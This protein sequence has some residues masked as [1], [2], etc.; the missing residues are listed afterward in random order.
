MVQRPRLVHNKHSPRFFPCLT[1]TS[2][3]AETVG[4]LRLPTNAASLSLLH[5]IPAFL[6]F[7][8][9]APAAIP[10]VPS[11]KNCGRACSTT[12]M[13]VCAACM[14]QTAS[15]CITTKR[16]KPLEGRKT[17]QRRHPRPV[18][19]HV[20]DYAADKPAGEL[21]RGCRRPSIGAGTMGEGGSTYEIDGIFGVF[22]W[23]KRFQR[24]VCTC[25]DISI[26]SVV[27]Y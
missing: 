15:N 24:S 17:W 14:Y 13:C 3:I 7:Y 19:R 5:P 21:C 23:R 27:F 11:G 20:R 8:A 9:G 26:R 18:P 6:P 12:T 22:V 16:T 1:C 25:G 4:M 2:P 10:I